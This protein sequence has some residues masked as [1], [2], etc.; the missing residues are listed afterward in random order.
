[1]AMVTSINDNFVDE[2]LDK[3]NRKRRVFMILVSK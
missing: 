2:N 1:M 3:E